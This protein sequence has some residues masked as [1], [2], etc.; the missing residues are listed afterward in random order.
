MGKLN[1]PW[2]DS[3]CILCGIEGHLTALGA[4]AEE[5]IIPEAIGGALTCHFFCRGCNSQLGSYESNLKEDPAFRNALGRLKG[6]IPYLYE[7]TLKRMA[8]ICQSELGLV[9]GFYRGKSGDLEFRVKAHQ[10]ADGS[11]VLPID[12]GD[13]AVS[14]MLRKKDFDAAGIEKALL[15]V[16]DASENTRV[17]LAP[18]LDVVKRTVTDIAPKLDPRRL[19]VQKDDEGNEV[20]TGAGIVLLKIAFEYLA[21]H[22]GADILSPVFDPIRKALHKNDASLCTY[23]VEWKLG[24]KLEPFYDLVVERSPHIVIQIRLLGELVYRVHFPNLKPGEQFRRCNYTHDLVTGEE[25][26]EEVVS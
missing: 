10:R 6:Q 14:E 20:L 24:S 25:Y 18:G 19:L 1:F 22:I 4:L 16:N 11:L 3:R 23:R 2:S 12:D 21:L 26:L 15:Q 17:T 5:H 13:K 7:E 9:D 8:F